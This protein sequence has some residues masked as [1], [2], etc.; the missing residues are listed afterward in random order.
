MNA[1][2]LDDLRYSARNVLVFARDEPRP[3]FDNGDLTSEAAVHLRELEPDVTASHD[4]EMLGNEIDIHH[5]AVRQVRNTVQ[6]RHVGHDRAG[7]D[8]DEYAWG[9]D[10]FAI[11]F[12]LP[13]RFKLRLT[14]VYSTILHRLERLLKARSRSSGYFIF[15][16]LHGLHINLDRSVN[17]NAVFPGASCDCC[18]ARA[19]D[20]SFGRYTACV[21][22]GA[23]KK[24]TLDDRYL[25]AGFG[26]PGRERR[27]RLS[28]SDDDRVVLCHRRLPKIEMQSGGSR[29]LPFYAISFFLTAY[30][31][32]SAVLCRF[33]FCMRF[34][35]CVSTVDT[36]MS[37]VAAASL[38]LRPSASSCR[39]SRSRSVRV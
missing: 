18:G 20:K 29:T 2:A 10:E 6:A 4:D 27:A 30:N 21:H 15:P 12:D 11:D 39:T 22:A 14:L 19:S 31:T 32:I 9:A 13:W 28:R 37:S 1:F 26:E 3:L 7:A 33:S 17:D 5:R 25:H 23:A 16:G 38:L 8:I 35:R 34:M 24:L 36:P